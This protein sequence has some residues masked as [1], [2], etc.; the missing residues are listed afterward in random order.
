MKLI[1]LLYQDKNASEIKKELSISFK[2]DEN[3]RSNAKNLDLIFDEF[4]A[5][6]KA[7]GFDVADGSKLKL[8]PKQRTISISD[9]QNSFN[10]TVDSD[11]SNLDRKEYK[12]LIEKTIGPDEC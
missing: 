8:S 11:F 6:I 4:L 12:S 10:G 3:P 1:T 9:F 5:F 2:V 7:S